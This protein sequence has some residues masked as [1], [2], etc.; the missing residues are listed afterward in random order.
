MRKFIKRQIKLNFVWS[1]KT[2]GEDFNELKLR[3]LR[4]IGSS[5]YDFF[6]L[7]TTLSKL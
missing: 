3:R 1:N 4:A 6:T 5:N 2:Y 7:F